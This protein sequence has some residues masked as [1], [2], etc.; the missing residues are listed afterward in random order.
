MKFLNVSLLSFFLTSFLASMEIANCNNP[1]GHAY[2][3]NHGIVDK[4]SSGWDKDGFNNVNAVFTLK[5]LDNKKLDILFIDAT[6]MITSVIQSGAKVFPV[7]LTQTSISIVVIHS[8]SV[9]TYSFWKNTEGE[10]KFS[11]SQSKTGD[12]MVRKNSLMVGNCS[13][14]FFDKLKSLLDNT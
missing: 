4:K 1:N 13:F 10:N 7:I 11:L 5:L 2:Y 8:T 14:I 9:E 6:K 3:H 12:I